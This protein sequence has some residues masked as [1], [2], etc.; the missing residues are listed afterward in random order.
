MKTITDKKLE[1]I[2]R[3]KIDQCVL[4]L[5]RGIEDR[6]DN[7]GDDW[8]KGYQAGLKSILWFFEDHGV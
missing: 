5:E 4:A 8:V 3:L 6:K 1:S 7:R 2:I